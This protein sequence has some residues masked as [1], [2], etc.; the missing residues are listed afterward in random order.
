[1]VRQT[2]GLYNR[3]PS[4]GAVGFADDQM[5]P[6]SDQVMKSQTHEMEIPFE[7]FVKPEANHKNERVFIYSS[8]WSLEITNLKLAFLVEFFGSHICINK[9]K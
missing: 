9:I 3:L 1:M 5:R 4:I 8:F 6:I 2:I 7:I